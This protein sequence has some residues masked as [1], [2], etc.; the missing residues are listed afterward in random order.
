MNLCQVIQG[1]LIECIC[2]IKM[3]KKDIAYLKFLVWEMLAKLFRYRWKQ[4]CKIFKTK[5]IAIRL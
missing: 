3:Y 1:S 2:D 4:D 5:I